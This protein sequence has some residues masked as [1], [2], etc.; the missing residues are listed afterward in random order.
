MPARGSR[1]KRHNEVLTYR[2]VNALAESLI[3]CYK[4]ELI[5]P[6]GPWRD[7]D[8]VELATL[9][10]TWW[11]NTERINEM[12]DDLTPTEVE[13]AYYAAQNRLTPTG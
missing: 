7:L 13:N 2:G 8:E 6:E 9:H 11:F 3:G 12:I 1:R 5:R 4:T 10:W